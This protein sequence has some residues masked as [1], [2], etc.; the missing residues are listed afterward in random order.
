MQG[1]VGARQWGL[2]PNFLK[3]M[4]GNYLTAGELALI[5]QRRG[6]NYDGYDC[7][8]RR[9][10]AYGAATTGIGL[11]AGLG[12]GA[13]LLAIAAAW[14]VNNASKARSRAA[15]NLANA[16]MNYV[17]QIA[18]FTLAERQSR[19]NWQVANSPT[20]RQYVDV[21]TGAGAFAGAGS[22]A[23]SSALAQ[24]E[25]TILTQGLLGNLNQCPQKVS[26]YSAP[27]PCSCPSGC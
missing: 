2:A 12:G 1:F 25:A 8:H 11:A 15:E 10:G 26:L 19:E 16:N 6:Y 27:Q 17:N 7:G 13:L 5:D 24:A 23:Q 9:G 22:N 18:A 3:Y 20:L 14:G 21:Q 4:E